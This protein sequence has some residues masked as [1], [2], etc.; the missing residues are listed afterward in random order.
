MH[1]Q[2]TQAHQKEEWEEVTP[3]PTTFGGA[4]L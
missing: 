1:Y 2:C 4:R 3:G